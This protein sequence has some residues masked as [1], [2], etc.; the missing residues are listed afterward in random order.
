MSM[1]IP[2]AVMIVYGCLLA[3]AAM[4]LD[5]WRGSQPQ[6]LH[7]NQAGDLIEELIKRRIL[8]LPERPLVTTGKK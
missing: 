6:K 8:T 5:G 1:L 7:A 4:F 2:F 3:L